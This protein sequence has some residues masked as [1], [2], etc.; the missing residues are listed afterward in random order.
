MKLKSYIISTFCTFILISVSCGST[1]GGGEGAAVTNACDS[2][3]INLSQHRVVKN[4]TIFY[5][6]EIKQKT[7]FI[8]ISK[9]Y[10]DLSVYAPMD[11]DTVLVARYP[12]CLS[13]NRGQKQKK[14]DM[15]TP[16][17]S[18]A[19][20]FKITPMQQ[21]SDW[22]HDFGDGR[23]SIQAYGKWFLRLYTPGHSGIGI[24]G[25][26]GNESSVPGRASEGCIR[27]RDPDIIHLK[28]NYAYTDM[29]VVVKHEDEDQYDFEKNLKLPEGKEEAT[30]T[31]ATTAPKAQSAQGDTGSPAVIPA[32]EKQGQTV[33]AATANGKAWKTKYTVESGDYLGKLAQRF[34]TTVEEIKE[35]NGLPDDRIKAGKVLLMP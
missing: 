13:K 28:E 29:K 10:L 32:G 20:P 18:M 33:P 25:S 27:M 16:E 3:S 15:K 8:V 12:V 9:K 35:V 7:A 2:D 4:R 19:N 5:D 1:T 22:K 17:C 30:A 21:S 11:S 31:K 34:H 14:G 23:G 26:T 6:G 24:H